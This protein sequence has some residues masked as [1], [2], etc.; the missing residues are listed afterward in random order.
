MENINKFVL[1]SFKII[2]PDTFDHLWFFKYRAMFSNLIISAKRPFNTK[3]AIIS[4][5][6]CSSVLIFQDSLKYRII[7]Y[8]F[9]ESLRAVS[10]LFGMMKLGT[11]YLRTN[12]TSF[13]L[14][15]FLCFTRSLTGGRCIPMTSCQH[16]QSF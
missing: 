15:V 13:V 8:C 10:F 14:L 7:S 6:T 12:K 11:L 3:K 16:M 5:F 4:F 2:K 9:L 1:K